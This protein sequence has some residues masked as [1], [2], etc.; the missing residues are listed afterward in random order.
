[1]IKRY[2]YQIRPVV[3]SFYLGENSCCCRNIFKLANHSREN[4][5]VM[6]CEKIGEKYYLVKDVSVT[7]YDSTHYSYLIVGYLGLILY[8]IGIPLGFPFTL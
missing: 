5:E 4:P 1:M 3:W 7:C 6:N 8:G 2:I